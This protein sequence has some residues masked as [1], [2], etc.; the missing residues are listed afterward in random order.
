[1]PNVWAESA[2]LADPAFRNRLE[3]RNTDGHVNAQSCQNG[4][5]E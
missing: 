1:M 3:D 5:V 4:N 2:K